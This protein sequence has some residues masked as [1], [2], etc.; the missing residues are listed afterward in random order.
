[1]AGNVAEGAV[2]FLESCG[3]DRD[4]VVLGPPPA[5]TL[6]SNVGSHLITTPPKASVARRPSRTPEPLFVDDGSHGDGVR[7]HSS[8]LLPMMSV[9][10][11]AH[12]VTASTSGAPLQ[13]TSPMPWVGRNVS[14]GGGVS[15]R[16][17]PSQQQQQAPNFEATKSWMLKSA[18]GSN[19]STNISRVPPAKHKF[20][21]VRRVEHNATTHNRNGSSSSAQQQQQQRSGGGVEGY[22]LA[23]ISECELASELAGPGGAGGTNGA[24]S[25]VDGERK[26][27]A[28][29]VVDTRFALVPPSVPFSK[30]WWKKPAPLSRS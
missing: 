13:A 6:T 20:A 5:T 30:Q 18:S 27:E 2:T 12:H 17:P 1:M 8:T 22:S 3:D 14:F 24:S 4:D 28:P 23:D 25:T 15:E 10:G 16:T 11:D 26:W 29:V 9:G 19:S 7:R 21:M